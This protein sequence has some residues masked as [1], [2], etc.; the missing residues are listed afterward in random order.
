MHEVL[1]S[2]K[3]HPSQ[4]FHKDLINFE[5]PQKFSKI[6]KVRSKGMKC[7]IKWGIKDLTSEEEQDQGLKTLGN[8]VCNERE[9]FGRWKGWKQS[10]EIQEKWSEIVRILDIET[11]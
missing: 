2:F 3:Q 9:E 10:R 5:K 11:S 8:E 1:N 6:P 4:K 7:M